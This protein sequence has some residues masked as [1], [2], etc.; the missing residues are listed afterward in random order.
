GVQDRGARAVLRQGG[1]P[2]SVV[3]NHRGNEQPGGGVPLL[4]EQL[5]RG[6][7]RAR[8]QT[9]AADRD[10]VRPDRRADQDAA[11]DDH[12]RPGREGEDGRAGVVGEPQ[13]VYV[14]DGGGRG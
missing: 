10:A 9:A 8:G 12:V 14:G 11:A 1:D 6:T 3:G 13:R 2:G 7:G 4:E 5:V